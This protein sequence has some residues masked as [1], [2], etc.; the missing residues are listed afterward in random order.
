LLCLVDCLFAQ[1]L[2]FDFIHLYRGIGSPHALW[3]LPGVWRYAAGGVHFR[4]SSTALSLDGPLYWSPSIQYRGFRHVPTV[5]GRPL[6][7]GL[8]LWRSATFES[9]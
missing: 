4:A 9:A 6:G 2:H 5:V 3:Q 7:S 8:S 1:P